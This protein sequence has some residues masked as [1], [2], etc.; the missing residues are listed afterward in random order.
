MPAVHRWSLAALCV[1]LAAAKVA[2]QPALPPVQQSGEIR[3]VT[4]GIGLDESSA[5]RAA[6]PQYNL[7]LTF[8][9][10]SGEYLA[11]ARVV[12]RDAQGRALL[13]T[14]SEGPY[15]FF[16]LPSGKYQVSAENAGETITRPVQVRDK[17]ASELIFRWKVAAE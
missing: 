6:A 12:L 16:R 3:Y 11:G 5:M 9:A 2:A 15:L 8:A 14:S 10:V 7:R 13:E 4:G 17:Q 1:A